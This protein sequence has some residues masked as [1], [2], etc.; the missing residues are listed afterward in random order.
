MGIASISPIAW[1]RSV[2]GLIGIRV[3]RAPKVLTALFR[4]EKTKIPVKQAEEMMR[5]CCAE[6]E[7]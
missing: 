2:S 3:R 6:D 1:L 7:R 5:N 4:K